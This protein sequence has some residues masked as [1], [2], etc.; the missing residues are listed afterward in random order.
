[1]GAYID[2]M[3]IKSKISYQ[4][5]LDLQEIFN[6][7]RKFGM[8]FNPKKCALGVSFGKFLEFMINERGIKTNPKKVKVF[9]D[10]QSPTAVKEVS[11]MT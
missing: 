7:L 8:K 2:N 5:L 9:F 10:M 6:N 1:M 3:I 11:K 4:H